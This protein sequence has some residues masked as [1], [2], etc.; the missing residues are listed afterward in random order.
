[1]SGTARYFWKHFVKQARY[2]LESLRLTNT[3]AFTPVAHVIDRVDALYQ[4][5]TE[6]GEENPEYAQFLAE[7]YILELFFDKEDNEITVVEAVRLLPAHI[8]R[9][10]RTR[11]LTKKLVVEVAIQNQK[12]PRTTVIVKKSKSEARMGEGPSDPLPVGLQT[13]KGT[14]KGTP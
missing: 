3:K 8:Y 4:R 11:T 1:M 13:P 9:L 6:E 14:P 5:H 2:L 7:A 10:P 12:H